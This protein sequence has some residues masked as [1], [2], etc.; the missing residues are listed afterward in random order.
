TRVVARWLALT[1]AIAAT[2]GWGGLDRLGLV[3]GDLAWFFGP[4][5]LAAVAVHGVAWILLGISVA[6]RR[7]TVV[8][9]RAAGDA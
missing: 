4:L 1:L 6:R 8:D 2:I 9:Q 5:T 3:G 7:R